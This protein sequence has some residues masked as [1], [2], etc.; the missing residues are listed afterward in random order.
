MDTSAIKKVV[1]GTIQDDY[2]FKV[3][4]YSQIKNLDEDTI[5]NEKIKI[6]HNSITKHF[7]RLLILTNCRSQGN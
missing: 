1:S 5:I 2:G 7:F 6:K 3:D 4:F